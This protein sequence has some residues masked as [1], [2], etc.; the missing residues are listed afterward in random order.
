MSLTDWPFGSLTPLK[1]G[2]L[3]ADPPW[4]YSMRSEKG[5]AKSPEA[6]YPTMPL[7]QIKALPVS[8]LAGK[9]CYLFLWSTWPHVPQAL[10]VMAAWGFDYVTGGSWTKRTVNWN[11]AMGTGYVLRSA[12]EPFL[13]GRIGRPSI[14]SRSER[15]VLLAPEDVPDSIEAIRREHSRKPVQMREMIDRLLPQSYFCELFAR[16][17]WE[18]HDVWGNEA[19]KFEGAT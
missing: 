10:E 15:N 11:V 2:A 4:A 1:Y 16:E 6:H 5:H 17:A 19:E 18:G 7:E 3:L 13:V 8:E 12:T 14:A 9:D